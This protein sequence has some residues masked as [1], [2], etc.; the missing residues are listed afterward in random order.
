MNKLPQ[1]ISEKSEKIIKDFISKR[2]DIETEHP[3][4]EDVFVIARKY[5]VIVKYPLDEEGNDAF[6]LSDVPS[7]QGPQKFIFINTSKTM[8]KQVFATAHELGHILKVYDGIEDDAIDEERIVNRFAAD[9]LMPENL[10]IPR[11][12][13]KLIEKKNN[14]EISFVDFINIVAEA[15]NYFFTTFDAVVIRFYELG[16]ISEESAT[17]LISDDLK[18]NVNKILEQIINEKDYKT[19]MSVTKT[20]SIDGLEG[21]L[22]SIEDRG[23]LPP[24]AVRLKDKYKVITKKDERDNDNDLI[25]L[26]ENF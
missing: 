13:E 26:Q 1:D 18:E 4:G 8:E 22:E 16:M 11:E 24:K 15:M 9:L 19:L 25:K 14:N 10:F 17:Y 6:L 2:L 3:L 21:L 7:K 5:A 12:K 23:E 20:K